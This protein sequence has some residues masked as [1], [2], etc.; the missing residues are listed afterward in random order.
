MSVIVFITLFRQNWWHM[1]FVDYG[2]PLPYKDVI[3]LEDGPSAGSPLIMKSFIIMFHFYLFAT[4]VVAK[5]T[6]FLP[7]KP[8]PEKVVARPTLFL[9]CAPQKPEL[10]KSAV[11]S[12]RFY[13]SYISYLRSWI[14]DRA[15]GRSSPPVSE[16]RNESPKFPVEEGSPIHRREWLLFLPARRVKMTTS[17]SCQERS[18]NTT[19]YG[20]QESL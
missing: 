9:P 19:P 20:W 17:S 18:N 14:G 1:M 11:E 2:W 4:M 5:P 10:E 15:T 6:L 8:E 16:E 3:R 12:E 13:P 7:K